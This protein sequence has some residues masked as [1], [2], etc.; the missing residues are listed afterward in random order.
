MTLPVKPDHIDKERDACP[1]VVS[2]DQSE[3]EGA[4][5]AIGSAAAKTQDREFAQPAEKYWEDY[6]GHGIR[7]SGCQTQWMQRPPG[8]AVTQEVQEGSEG[9]AAGEKSHFA[10][11]GIDGV[12]CV[13]NHKVPGSAR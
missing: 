7:R 11:V 3:E 8:V 12:S 13:F 6:M 5:T 9:D 2:H 10:P 4:G 1:H